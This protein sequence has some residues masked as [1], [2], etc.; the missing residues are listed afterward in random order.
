[1]SNTTAYSYSR[2]TTY[3]KCSQLYKL[4]YE[5]RLKEARQ[6][7]FHTRLGTYCHA[8]LEEFYGCED[9]SIESPYNALVREGGVWDKELKKLGLD[10]VEADLRRYAGHIT[11]LYVRAHVSYRGSDAIRNKD[12]KV[13]NAPQF[14]GAWKEHVRQFGLDSM[15]S[16]IDRMAGQ[17]HPDWQTISLSDVYAQSLGM[18]YHYKNPSA[19]Q[20]IV[21]IELAVSE[22]WYQA[23]DEEGKLLKGVKT[24]KARGTHKLWLDKDGKE[25]LIEILNE[26]PMPL[27]D[28]TGLIKKDTDGK[29][30]WSKHALFHGYIDLLARDE[31]GRLLIIDHKTSQELPTEAKVARH[32]QLLA[33]GFAVYHLTGELP[34]AI[35]INHLRSNKLVIAKFDL[36]RA[37]IAVER[38]ASIQKG[39]EIKVFIKRDP[40]GWDSPCVR[41]ATRAD[42][43]VILCPGLKFC[44]ESVWRSYRD[45][46]SEQDLF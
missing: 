37:E 15:A 8:A 35:G 26:Q 43:D 31:Q 24:T 36:A 45:F 14:S 17:L 21:A 22:V 19:I 30:E 23:A 5:L 28:D 44:H 38:L 2:L 1:M 27:L 39:I 13:S 18:M 16:K 20:S 33:Y 29:P 40:D 4:L 12:G 10:S 9:G 25:K 11:K 6:D 3:D 7:T 41:K 34:H 46:T 42:R 32:E